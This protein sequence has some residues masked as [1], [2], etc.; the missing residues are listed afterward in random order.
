MPWART[1]WMSERVKVIA[2]W[3]PPNPYQGSGPITC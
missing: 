3:Q 1:D 2:V